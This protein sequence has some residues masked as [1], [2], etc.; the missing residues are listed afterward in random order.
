MYLYLSMNTN[1]IIKLIKNSR[2]N[3]NITQKQLSD[4]LKIDRSVYSRI[5]R[6]EYELKLDLC[7]R[8][9]EVLKITAK[10]FK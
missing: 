1:D 3:Q 6:G 7:F 9:C 5:E 8:I 10:V 4:I 2:I